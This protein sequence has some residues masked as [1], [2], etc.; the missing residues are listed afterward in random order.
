MSNLNKNKKIHFIYKTTNVLNNNYYIGVHST[1]NMNDGYLGSGKRLKY[2]INKYGKEN[3]KIE[4][5]EMVESRELLFE[6]ERELVNQDILKDPHCMNLKVGGNGGIFSNEHMKKLSKYGNDAFRHKL[7][8][9]IEFREKF[10]EYCKIASS[11]AKKN[12]PSWLG[13]KHKNETIQKLREIRKNTCLGEKNSQYNTMWITNGNEN[14]KIKK[15]DEIP[16]GWFI[17]RKM[18]KR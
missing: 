13:K 14:M 2:S 5:I 7:K 12:P 4:I 15:N 9:N 11:K 18:K 8:T 1:N 10:I 3:F 6:R 16:N 17:G